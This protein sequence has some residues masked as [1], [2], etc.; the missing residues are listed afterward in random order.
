MMP[1]SPSCSGSRFCIAAPARRSALNVPIKL[2]AMTRSKSASGIGPSRPTMRLAGPMPAQLIRMRGVPWS[3]AALE[4][5]ASVAAALVT[6]QVIAMPLMSIATSAAAF[7][8]TSKIATLAPASASMRAVAAPSPEAPPVTIA[9][10]PRM[11]MVG[12]FVLFWLAGGGDDVGWRRVGVQVFDQARAI[13][14][15]RTLV[16]GTLVGHLADVERRQF[17]EQDGAADAARR[18]AARL[19]QRVEEARELGAHARVGEQNGDSSIGGETGRQ[20]AADIG[21]GKHQRGNVVTVRAGQHHVAHQQ[22]EMGDE[23]SAQRADADP[24]P[25][26]ELEIFGEAAVEQEALGR[27]GRVGELDRVADLVKALVVERVSREMRRLV[28]TGSDVDAFEPRFELAVARHELELHAGQRQADIASAFGFPT[29][30]NRCRR[31][32][33]RAETR[34]KH[35]ALAC[36]LD[37]EPLDGVG[38]M[39]RQA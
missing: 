21:I 10:C 8:L 30:G 22:C 27:I 13:C 15:H 34:Q 37:R 12:S 6:S 5:A 39:L 33:R 9:A 23:S 32:L 17:G 4:N 11:S 7:A 20:L 26:R 31:R 19:Q 16:D 35:D 36:G 2:M 29:A 3:A 18:A 28:I 25:G 24:G 1:R 14:K 38:D